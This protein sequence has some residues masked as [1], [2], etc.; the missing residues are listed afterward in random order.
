MLNQQ[1]LY[2]DGLHNLAFYTKRVRGSRGRKHTHGFAPEPVL[3]ITSINV[4]ESPLNKGEGPTTT[5][6]YF[7]AF[8]ASSA[9]TPFPWLDASGLFFWLYRQACL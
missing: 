3:K 2:P 4:F 7:P 5:K 6:P 8:H 1:S 9:P